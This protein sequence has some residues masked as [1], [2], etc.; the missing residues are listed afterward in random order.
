MERTP[1]RLPLAPVLAAALSAGCIPVGRPNPFDE[2]LK[3][4]HSPKVEEY[5]VAF[6]FLIQAGGLTLPR[7]KASLP[8]GARRGFPG[9]ALLYALGEGD[10]VPLELRARHLAAFRWPRPYQGENAI[11]EPYAW[12]ELE[13]DLVKAGRPALRLLADAL[14]REAPSEAKALHVARVMLR[15]GGRPAAEE[16]ARLLDSGRELDGARV[17]DVAAGALLYLGRQELALREGTR[18]GLVRAARAWWAGAKDRTEEEWAQEAAAALAD[19][20]RPGDPEGVRP[21]LE[22]L[23]GRTVED[24]KDWREKNPDWRPAPAPLRP[25]TLLPELAAGRPRAYEANRRLEAA[26]GFRLDVPRAERLGDLCAALRLW[27]PPPDLEVRWKRYLESTLLRLSITVIGRHP[28]QGTNQVV[29]FYE[30]TFHGTEDDSGELRFSSDEGAYQLYAQARD[31]GTRLVFGEY[32]FGED[33]Q[34]GVTAEYSAR[35]PV[36][37]FSRPLKAC[38]LIAVDE[39]TG[40]RLPR[41]PELLLAEAR[42]RLRAAADRSGPAD[43]RKVLRALGYC[44]DRG[45]LDFLKER[46]AG[47]ALLLLGDPAA[48]DGAPEL[49][50]HEIEMA[51]ARAEDPRVREYLEKLQNR[52]PTVR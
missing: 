5:E 32:V 35:H 11:V 24:P 6:Q 27:Q 39:V 14:A 34:R 29:G 50:P 51:L 42:G 2:A 45:D 38:I 33:G 47:E 18:E 9:V 13:R 10:A 43:A 19:R 8:A 37:V 16:F 23:V 3:R 30:T 20:F 41:P 1:R 25:E 36:V 28:K 7:L 26:T 49:E 4:L 17:Q 12:N 48:L 22:L 15:I 31:F 44:Q 40:R 21:V 52:T 46:R